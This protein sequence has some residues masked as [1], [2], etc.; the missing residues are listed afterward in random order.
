MQENCVWMD[1]ECIIIMENHVGGWM[2][3]TYAWR[4]VWMDEECII[5]MENHVRMDE[6]YISMENHVGG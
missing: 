1:E 2:K 3:S 5:F 4:I 6:E